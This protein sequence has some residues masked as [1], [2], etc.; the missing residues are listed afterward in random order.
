[1]SIA[2]VIPCLN[3]EVTI[4]DVVRACHAAIPE[5]AIYVF[6]NNSTDQT[7]ARAEAAGAHVVKS[8]RPGKGAVVRHAFATIEAEYY[9]LIDGDGT[10][11]ATESR[12]LVDLARTG[13]YEMVNAARLQLGPRPAFRPLHF[14]GNVMFTNIVRR[15]FGHQILDLLTGFRVFS[16]AFVKG[17]RLTSEGFEIETELTIRALAEERPL[18]EVPVEYQ[19]RPVGSASKLRT[20]RDGARI[21]RTIVSLALEYRP[22]RR[23]A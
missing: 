19:E 14:A 8:P 12:R 7:A 6:D 4:A 9:V 15:T 21:S 18:L 10:Y 16:R 20:F 23:V 2:F 3:E 22:R 13:G 5:A 17:V 1:M 11:P